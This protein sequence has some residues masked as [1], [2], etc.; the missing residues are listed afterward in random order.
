LNK[1]QP[2]EKVLVVGAFPHRETNI[3]GGFL[4]VCSA[5]KSSSF[6]KDF[7]LT[8]VDTTQKSNPA[9]NLL[10]RAILAGKRVI[11]FLFKVVLYRPRVAIIFCSSGLSL[12]EKG[13][14][15]RFTGIC[16]IPTILAPGGGQ[17]LKDF[18]QS[19]ALKLFAKIAFKKTDKILCQG[20]EWQ[21]FLSSNFKRNID[22]LPIVGNWTATRELLDVGKS[23]AY[24]KK[25][26]KLNLLFVG[27]LDHSKG[28]ID[29]LEAIQS[30]NVID[31]VLLEFVGEGNV[32]GEA[33]RIVKDRSIGDAVNFASWLHGEKLLQAYQKADVFI[34]PSWMEG[35]PNAMIEAM[36]AGLCVVVSSVGNIPSTIRHL[37]NGILIAPQN[38]AT[39]VEALVNLIENDQARIEMGKKAHLYASQNFSTDIAVGKLTKVV[40]KLLH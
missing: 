7:D 8:L 21:E 39:I 14:M 29:L 10:I 37:E 35:L 36:S 4:T 3:F 6:S 23:R 5:L 30:K 33:R 32:S 28:V 1:I 26:G 11:Q 9:P 40:K 2:K 27:W 24:R 34:L 12:L 22:D 18:H 15:G 19:F 38:P 20:K 13:L 25:V 16:G 31:H 17:L